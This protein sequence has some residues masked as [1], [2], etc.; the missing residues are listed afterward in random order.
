MTKWS[1]ELLKTKV[2]RALFEPDPDHTAEERRQIDDLAFF[3]DGVYRDRER[4]QKVRTRVKKVLA[5]RKAS[6]TV[7]AVAQAVAEELDEIQQDL[8]FAASRR[9]RFVLFANDWSQSWHGLRQE[10]RVRDIV[11][12]A[13]PEREALVVGGAVATAT[14]LVDLVQ[15]VDRHP[16][17]VPIEFRVTLAAH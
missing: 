17:G 8:K 2:D 1:E 9:G 14:D 7:T 15:L 12:G 5:D 10:P 13:N 4:I 3:S 11:V 6:P 16:A